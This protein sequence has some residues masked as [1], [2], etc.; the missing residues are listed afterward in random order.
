MNT[1]HFFY[2]M[3]VIPTLNNTSTSWYALRGNK[4][5][6]SALI[7]GLLVILFTFGY[8]TESRAQFPREVINQPCTACSPSSVRVADLDN[9]SSLDVIFS[10]GAT[11]Y[12]GNGK[13]AWYA[14]T[15]D[16]F[17]SQKT[18]TTFATSFE[19]ADLD[20]DG[21]KDIILS[22]IGRGSESDAIVWYE[23]L[24][25]GGV[26]STPKT[27][28][29]SVDDPDNIRITDL[30]GDGHQDILFIS[31]HQ[32]Q[33]FW[34]ENSS[35]GFSNPKT[36]GDTA[37]EYVLLSIDLD[38]DHD[39]DI[40]TQYDGNLVSYQHTSSGFASRKQVLSE[41]DVN[42]L[43]AADLDGDNIKDLL[44]TSYN[45]G[46]AWY[47][48]RNGDG[49]SSTKNVVT[50]SGLNPTEVIAADLDG[51]D[52][53][54]VLYSSESGNRVA[55]F[56]NL[57][58]GGVST[59]EN[60]ITTNT[61]AAL[62]VF[63]ADL[64]GDND[65]DVLSASA[66]DDK[67]AWYRNELDQNG[68]FVTEGAIN[69]L[70]DLYEPESVLAADLDGDNDNDVLTASRRDGKIAW[71]ETRDGGRFSSQNVITTDANGAKSVHA[72]DLDG[73]GDKDVLSASQHDNTI[74]WYENLDFGGVSSTRTIISTNADFAEDVHAADLNGD[75][76]K[77]VLSA[78]LF[79]DKIAWY[80]NEDAGFS[81]EK[82]ITTTADR[83]QSVYSAD[84]DGDGDKD[85]VAASEGPASEASAGKIAWYE[86]LNSG[87]FSSENPLTTDV[88]R[89]L[90]AIPADLDGDGEKDVLSVTRYDGIGWYENLDSGGFSSSRNDI[91]T[92][93]NPT[94]GDNLPVSVYTDDLDGD[95]DEDVVV[96]F[97]ASLVWYENLEGGG[98]SSQRTVSTEVNGGTS[99][100]AANLDQDFDVDIL[101]ASSSNH[102]IAWYEN[103]IG[104]ERPTAP[105]GL[106]AASAETSAVDLKWRA[107][108]N[109]AVQRYRIYRST[110]PIGG[111]PSN[112]APV[113]SVGAGTTSYVDKTEVGPTYYYRVTTVDTDGTESGFSGQSSALIYPEKMDISIR[114]TFGGATDSKN[115][116]LV[117]L[118]GQVDRSLSDAV[119]GQ[120]GRDWQAFHDDGSD[121]DYLVEYDGSDTFHFEP[122]NGFWFASTQEWTVDDAVSTV[123]LRGDS[124][125]VIDLQTGW[126]VISNPTGKD[127]AWNW[128]DE[129]AS[130]ALQPIWGFQGTFSRADTFRSATTGTAYYFFN[131]SSS[132][133]SL[134]I[135]YRSVPTS[136][137]V[138]PK[139]NEDTPKLAVTAAPALQEEAS[140][141]TVHIGLSEAA[142]PGLGAEDFVAPPS[143]FAETSLRIKAPGGTEST[144]RF[145]MTE[146]RP[147]S[148]GDGHTFHLQLG[149]RIEGPVEVRIDNLSAIDGRSVSLLHS[150][151]GQ[152]YDLDDRSS[153][154]VAPSGETTQLELVIGTDGYVERKADDVVPKQVQLTS[155]PNPMGPQGTI[156]YALPEGQE[157]T[158][159]IYD[160]LGREVATLE[161]GRKQAGRHTV[162][163]ETDR[164]S[165]GIYFG[166]LTAGG[167]TLTQKI[168]VVR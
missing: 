168:T 134:V 80:E 71:Y 165:S 118:P 6:W 136:K 2:L 63:A 54:D 53:K 123:A 131:D 1:R 11:F 38:G 106:T 156:E 79:D 24:D 9:D 139:S 47:K 7:A 42:N 70:P 18:V 76:D 3:S 163:L 128:I 33:I 21:D 157:V 160:V 125:A 108:D 152:T 61:Q 107:V 32:E 25:N 167:Q 94:L 150:E 98:F 90:G 162:Q 12:A 29:S 159:R 48:N 58:D 82:I 43:F 93:D 88:N 117:A 164:L 87:G 73:D 112:Y 166:R 149:S 130:D 40:L 101:S 153:V 143:R 104:P 59:I 69:T 20:D 145:L 89:L 44:T 56:E 111:S 27:L 50:S 22:R 13:V 147:P 55:W 46:V 8:A 4:T 52:D 148:D 154:T 45:G 126:N 15:T 140:G 124:A 41:I 51:D 31:K 100:F 99:L 92:F 75:G 36:I 83:A 77:D 127:I 129:T 116:R 23:N 62:S 26:S 65:K 78:S 122:G 49:L 67:V 146:Q 155:Y 39:K 132:R 57:D 161:S 115:Y 119:T 81:S 113:D 19:T 103:T 151:A 30:D 64:D 72:A 86:N 109:D 114:R 91:A 102:E 120:A 96:V 16:G 37:W 97:D 10:T 74:A 135:P 142:N 110:T 138:G 34:L 141:S 84:F 144:R 66:N 105:S 137:T 133:D 17:S 95:S 35:A 85:V 5:R 28:T 158:L 121:N 60:P 14:N 68:G